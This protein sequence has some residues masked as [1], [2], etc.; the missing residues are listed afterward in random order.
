MCTKPIEIKR[1]KH[2][3]INI[4]KVWMKLDYTGMHMDKI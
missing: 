4:M 2:K 1:K 3:N